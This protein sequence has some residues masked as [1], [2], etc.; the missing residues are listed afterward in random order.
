MRPSLSIAFGSGRAGVGKSTLVANLAVA[1]QR[2]G[3]RCLLWDANIS[4]P[5]LHTLFGVDPLLRAA[6]AYF[7]RV[8]PEEVPLELRPG[9]W[10]FAERATSSPEAEQ[11]LARHFQKLLQ[12]IAER[13]RPDVVLL[14][15]PAGWSEL[16]YLGCSTAAMNCLVLGDDIG[17]VLDAYGFLKALSAQ[18]EALTVQLIVTNVVDSSDAAEIAQ[19]L[20]TVAARF[21]GRRFPLLGEVPYDPAHRAALLQQRPLVEHLPTA[22]AAQAYQRLAM[23]LLQALQRTHAPRASQTA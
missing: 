23:A 13:L 8:Q 3:Y 4:A 11:L 17:S 15:L 9:L 16:V 14:D 18:P 20:N 10:L 6:D 2:Q 7:G 19:K 5:T 1:L 21:L 12:R 22:P